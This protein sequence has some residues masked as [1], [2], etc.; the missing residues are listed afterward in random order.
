MIMNFID[1]GID[2]VEYEHINGKIIDDNVTKIVLVISKGNYGTIDAADTSC[3]GYYIKK[4]FPHLH[5]LFNKT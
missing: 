5:I 4:D 3:H 2:T 1:G